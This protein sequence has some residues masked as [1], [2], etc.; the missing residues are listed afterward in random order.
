LVLEDYVVNL[1]ELQPLLEQGSM[2]FERAHAPNE[3][4]YQAIVR[5]YRERGLG[6]LAA[7][8]RQS[9][10][11]VAQIAFLAHADTLRYHVTAEDTSGTAQNGRTGE[12]LLE[13]V[14]L[15]REAAS[16]TARRLQG[17][18]IDWSWASLPTWNPS[19]PGE[20]L[21]FFQEAPQGAALV[22]VVSKDTRQGGY[23]CSTI[24]V[25]GSDWGLDHVD[26]YS[27]F[28]AFGLGV[29]VGSE[30]VDG[31]SSYKFEQGQATYWLDAETLWLQKYE[32]QE[33]GIRYTVKLEAV[34][35]DIRI[36][37]P[38]VDVPCVE[39]TPPG[40]GTPAP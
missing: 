5:E 3:A 25:S 8:D 33:S 15:H 21:E 28:R 29:P 31:R 18:A 39:E 30:I 38:D 26:Y 4:E 27:E 16:I 6:G 2:F 12:A 1:H 20:K 19:A 34:N 23:A 9:L 24:K 37:P 32:Y 22:T 35:E 10:L 13:E 14:Y 7:D 11:L 40:E 17:T 36:E